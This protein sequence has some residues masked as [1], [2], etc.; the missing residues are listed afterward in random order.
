[1]KKKLLTIAVAA[2]AL[3]LA[4]Q[5]A[6]PEFYGR[7]NVDLS[8]TA[9]ENSSSTSGTNTFGPTASSWDVDD[10]KNWVGVRGELP[11]YNDNLKA[12]YQI[13]RGVDINDKNGA[14]SPRNTYVGL[15]GEKWGRVFV[16]TYDSVVK[17]AEGKADKFNNTLAEMD[18]YISGQ[19]RYKNTINYQSANMGGLTVNL[20]VI[21]GEASRTDVT[22]SSPEL[23]HSLADAYGASVNFVQETFWA[24]LAYEQSSETLAISPNNDFGI[25]TLRATAG[26]DIGNLH[27]AVLFQQRDIDDTNLP[28]DSDTK[29]A[30]LISGAFDAT[31]QLT[32]KAQYG[33]AEQSPLLAPFNWDKNDDQTV[34]SWA[35]GA[36]YELGKNVTTYVLYQQNSIDGD[37]AAGVSNDS[38]LNIAAVGLE[39]R[40]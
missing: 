18:R 40:F 13:E 7:L 17:Q 35:I 39:L 10:Y 6:S 28:V 34:K 26:V 5:A 19:N 14:L 36:D 2:A 25:S 16:G 9:Y 11:L 38:E 20:Q 24:H 31:D 1:M 21:P 4:A 32:V 23:E 37:N 15:A 27:G 3:P 12:I 29:N 33:N 22:G 8:N 30:W